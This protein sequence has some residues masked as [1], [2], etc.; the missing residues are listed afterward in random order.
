M[1]FQLPVLEYGSTPLHVACKR[2]ELICVEHL[3]AAGAELDTVDSR[4]LRPLD[5]VGENLIENR[6]D[7]DVEF[8][9]VEKE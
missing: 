7:G 8:R 6:E 9:S 4:G 5:V 1:N 3:L 2:T